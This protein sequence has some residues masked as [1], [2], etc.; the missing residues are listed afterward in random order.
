MKRSLFPF[1][2]LL[3]VVVIFQGFSCSDNP[4]GP[5][6]EPEPGMDDISVPDGF[7][8]SMLIPIDLEIDVRDLNDRPL[9]GIRARVFAE[10]S[11]DI[12]GEAEIANGITGD[13]GK[14]MVSLNLPS[15]LETVSVVTDLVGAVNR[16][17]FASPAGTVRHTFGGSVPGRHPVIP[18]K[19]GESRIDLNH[20]PDPVITD[21]NMSIIIDFIAGLNEIA[22]GSEL[23]CLT[24]DEI[25]AG[26]VT[27]EGD[28]PWGMAAWGDDPLSE[29]IDGFR[30][31]EPLSFLMW[32][33]SLQAELEPQVTVL[34]GGDPVYQTNALLIIRLLIETQGSMRYLGSWDAD[35]V[36]DYKE[37]SRRV[38]DTELIEKLS[39]TA[40]EN[41]DMRRNQPGWLAVSADLELLDSAEVTV[42][43]LHEGTSRKNAVGYY[44]YPADSPPQSDADISRRTIIFPNA[45][46][47]GHGGGLQQGDAVRIKPDKLPP[48]TGIGWFIAVDAWDGNS[49]GDTSLLYYAN[50]AFNPENAAELKKHSSIIFDDDSESIIIGFEDFDRSSS[51]H[52][53]NDLMFAVQVSPPGALNVQGIPFLSDIPPPADEDGDG[54]P[55][56]IDSEPQ[57]TDQAFNLY[58]PAA[59][60]NGTI[61]FETDWTG[62]GDYDFNDLVMSFKF[63]QVTNALGL[64]TMIEGNFSV[65]AVGSA[66]VTGF[67]IEL[68]FAPGQVEN[69]SGSVINGGYISLDGNN[70]ENGQDHAV[71][72]VI[73]DVSTYIRPP[74][75]YAYVN[76]EPGSPRVEAA[77]I[78]LVIE[79]VDPVLPADYDPPPF[80]PFIILE[81][82]RGREIHP[83]NYPPTN[84]ADQ[85]LFGSGSD[86]S[87]PESGIYYISD[88]NLPWSL[89]MPGSWKHPREGAAVNSAYPGFYSW[90]ESG[91][92]SVPGWFVPVPGN[93]NRANIWEPE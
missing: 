20:F 34:V 31:G 30:A 87:I 35:G 70:T 82:E 33:P 68:P 6:Q 15:H 2:F 56:L 76:T 23:A 29:D 64:I 86:R 38:F 11:T 79:L 24:P 8:F 45:S 25:V 71:V 17:D 62:T 48:Q 44:T 61:A 10:P 73:D 3:F 60:S 21:A 77:D 80:N 63:R 36:P 5:E 53:F 46:F 4:A 14:F 58:F 49:V 91:G 55:D 22:E 32:D 93:M 59:N 50:S 75:S 27:L 7:D 47:S 81:R 43:F 9:A 57:E 16:E 28:P 37:D 90:A 92:G 84:L 41:I 72:I 89:L 1:F 40:F 42:T 18:G 39:Q 26:A 54:I 12:S 78:R 83:V 74:A 13:D 19:S 85:E 66:V 65:N 88:R 67:G 51:D 69:V 52:D